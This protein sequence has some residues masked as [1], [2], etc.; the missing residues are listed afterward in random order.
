MGET[1]ELMVSIA[2][3]W[4]ERLVLGEHA[5]D[6]VVGL[7]NEME[8]VGVEPGFSMVEKVVSS[9]WERGK[10]EVGVEF[11]KSVMRRGRVG[12]T[13]LEDERIWCRGTRLEGWHRGEELRHRRG[14]VEGP[15]RGGDGLAV[16]GSDQAA[17]SK[18]RRFVA[19]SVTG[20]GTDGGGG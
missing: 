6:V 15:A 1:M 8:C 5:V 19:A 18:R 16:V 12:G 13:L 2:C 9:Y 3:G 4:I 11:V 7:L 20:G 14:G 17:V 10:K